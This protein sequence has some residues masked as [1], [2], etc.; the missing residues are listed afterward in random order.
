MLH[1]L[2][3]NTVWKTSADLLSRLGSAVFW[4]L[5]ARHLGA[6]S[7]GA[8]AFTLS[9]YSFFELAST[10]GIGSLI[11][12]EVAQNR[13]KMGAYFSHAL[14]IGL[15]CTILSAPL[16]LFSIT[17]LQPEP[18]TRWSGYIMLL[19][20]LPA[21]F[22]YWSKVMLT[23][24]EDLRYISLTAVCE[25][26]VL[27][28]LGLFFLLTGH[29]LRALIIVIA[30]SKMIAAA[31]AFFFA[32]RRGAAPDWRLD[33]AL[34]KSLLRQSSSFFFITL[35]NSAFWSMTI[36]MLTGMQGEAAAGYFNAAFKLIS[37][38]LMF[39]LSFSQ[40]L[41]PV[42]SRMA[43]E[44]RGLY[45]Q[46]LKRA[47]RYQAMVFTGLAIVLSLSAK[48]IIA[49]LY[50]SAMAPAGDVLKYLAWML[51]PY[52][53]IPTLAYTL[54]SHRH[55]RHDLWANFAGAAVL[56]A[57]SLLLIPEFSS[58]GAAIALTLGTI[59][60]AFIEYF[61]VHQHLYRLVP[62]RHILS[63]GMAGAL[64]ALCLHFFNGIHAAG[65]IALGG[66]VYVVTLWFTR[67]L[68]R[69]D[70]RRLLLAWIPLDGKGVA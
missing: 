48:P 68:D 45:G 63:I 11:T 52:G 42:A 36:I 15:F 33:R 64:M 21:S 23:A 67:S 43:Q 24:A 12:R 61:S 37:Y 25:N 30:A 57:A 62:D 49:W 56:L 20:L 38:A 40:A 34:L 41:L 10:L 55:A 3:K 13:H 66:L 19:V 58:T 9:L 46:F 1:S 14:F 69:R 32:C 54:I 50:G 53:I 27:I 8:I 47:L 7:F 51:I 44:D 39:T 35:F 31:V 65:A 70:V 26:A 2:L 5:V 4:I 22:G 28:G 18:A 6:G 29:G 60:F 59:M 17:W 16:M